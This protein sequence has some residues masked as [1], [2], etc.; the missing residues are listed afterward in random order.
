VFQALL[1]AFQ[2]TAGLTIMDEIQYYGSQSLTGIF[3]S[4]FISWVGI[5]VIV[6]KKRLE[7]DDDF[8]N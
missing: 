2:I 5:S 6:L 1:L 7:D 4:A 3:F 8:Q